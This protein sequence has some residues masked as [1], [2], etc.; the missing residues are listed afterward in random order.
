MNEI[1]IFALLW[2]LGIVGVVY[3]WDAAIK[4]NGSD[5]DLPKP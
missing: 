3:L 4:R 1:L 5:D 2:S